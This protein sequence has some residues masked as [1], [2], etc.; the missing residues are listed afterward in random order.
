MN[1]K[2]ED[3]EKSRDR[4]FVSNIIGTS[5]RILEVVGGVPEI[6]SAR[7]ARAEGDQSGGQEGKAHQ[8]CI[9]PYFPPQ[10]CNPSLAGQ[11]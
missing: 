7:I 4:F 8:T 2:S 3:R 6:S 5:P 9:S 10:L 1:P 11:L